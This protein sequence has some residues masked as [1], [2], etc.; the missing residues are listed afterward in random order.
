MKTQIFQERLDLSEAQFDAENRVIRNVVLIRAGM[1]Q[2]RK[3][4][5]ETVL[6]AAAAKFD[7]VKA[8]DSHKRGARSVAELTGWYANV[9]YSEGKLIADRYFTTTDAGRNVMHVAQDIVE[10]RAPA[11]LAGLSINAVGTGKQQ[12]FDDGD[13]IHVESITGVTSVDDVDSPAAGGSYLLTA[14]GG[15][16]LTTQVLQTMTFEEWFETRPDFVERV[17]KELKLVRQDDAVKA[18]K[19]EADHNR[20]TLIEAQ[21][22]IETLTQ[23]RDAALQESQQARRELA[24]ER[25]LDGSRLPATHKNDLR[26]RFKT[27]DPSQWVGIIERESEKAKA[28]APRPVV[29][30]AGVQVN[31]P[32]PIQETFDPRPRDDEDSESYARRMAQQRR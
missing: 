23:E 5:P 1:S 12:K 7:G 28:H 16:E 11:T 9:R 4:Y 6:Q 31:T 32:Q 8:Y 27:T 21:S 3:H 30:G 17:H 10:Q 19:A 29:T 22:M 15:D 14:S 2:N 13:A 18:A 26:E 20:L 24:I 25:A